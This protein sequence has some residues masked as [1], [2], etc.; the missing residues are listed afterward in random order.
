MGRTTERQSSASVGMLG[1]LVN[2]NV[3]TRARDGRAPLRGIRQCCVRTCH[4]HRPR[5]DCGLSC[6]IKDAREI[7]FI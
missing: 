2:K 3:A 6:E 1:R 4:G 7:V 5:G